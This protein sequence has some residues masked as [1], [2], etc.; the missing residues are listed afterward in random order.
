MARKLM[1]RRFRYDEHFLS[2]RLS[3]PKRSDC[4]RV[5]RFFSLVGARRMAQ[6]LLHRHFQHGE[7]FPSQRFSRPQSEARPAFWYFF[8]CPRGRRWES[9]S[10]HDP[11]A[12]VRHHELGAQRALSELPQRK[13]VQTAA[14]FI[15]LFR[16]RLVSRV[17]GVTRQ[18]AVDLAAH[19]SGTATDFSTIV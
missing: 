11:H 16:E 4:P 3:Q 10:C 9:G 17:L 13:E 7:H 1:Y 14:T 2:H 5:C 19:A 6:K 18:H 15:A 12:A 8:T